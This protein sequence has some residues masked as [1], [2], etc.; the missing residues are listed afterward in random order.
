MDLLCYSLKDQKNL[1]F[2]FFLLH[3]LGF[4]QDFVLF[5]LKAFHHLQSTCS[6]DLIC[7]N[8]QHCVQQTGKDGYF[9]NPDLG[10][11][12]KQHQ[13]AVST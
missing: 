1:H 4:S 11:C 7:S 3:D 8:D 2:Q 10:I 6:M 5:N 13:P 12:E 9:C